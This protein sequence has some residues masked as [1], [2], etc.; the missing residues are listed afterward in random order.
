MALQE[1]GHRGAAARDS[2]AEMFAQEVAEALLM[3]AQTQGVAVRV[4]VA[5]ATVL[6]EVADGGSFSVT[7]AARST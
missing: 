1:Q 3:M 7:V 2:A 6:A 4:D 5:G